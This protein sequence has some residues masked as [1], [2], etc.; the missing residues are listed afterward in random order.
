MAAAGSVKP[1]KSPETKQ[2]PL[3]QGDESSGLLLVLNWWK[4]GFLEGGI[5]QYYLT[6]PPNCGEIRDSVKGIFS[7]FHH[8]NYFL[9]IIRA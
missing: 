2:K 5:N 9:S 1:S 7:I 6:M 4:L 3:L 8:I